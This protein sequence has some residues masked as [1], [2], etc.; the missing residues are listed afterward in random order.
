MGD[1]C[2]H[3]GFTRSWPSSGTKTRSTTIRRNKVFL[4][5][6]GDIY[7]LRGNY[8]QAIECWKRIS[9][10][11]P[12][13]GQVRSKITGLEATSTMDRGGYEGAKTTQEVRRRPTTTIGRRLKNTF[14]MRSRARA[15]LWKPICCGPSARTRPK[16]GATSSWRSSTGKQKEFAKANE[17]LQQAF[18]ATRR[19]LQH[20]AEHRGRR[21]GAPAARDRAGPVIGQG[22]GGQEELEALEAR[23]ASARDR[24]PFV[25]RRA[26]SDG[27]QLEVR[28]GHAVHEV[29]GVQEGDSPSAAGDRR[30]APRASGARGPWQ[31][32]HCRE[33]TEAG[34]LPV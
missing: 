33:A 26:L 10:L 7:E 6:M 14:P 8:S 32:L 18:E 5:K 3:L 13:N 4:E 29:Q 23:A 28:L 15:S 12:N 31:M 27:R 9:K 17:I 34:P 30:P 1:A 16:R 20:P 19:G 22:R 24:D 25:A 21:A 2:F 11:D